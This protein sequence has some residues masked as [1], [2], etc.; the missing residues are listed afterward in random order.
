VPIGV[1]TLW[2]ITKKPAVDHQKTGGRS[3][4]TGALNVFCDTPNRFDTGSAGRA[5]V[6][7]SF[8]GVAINATAQGQ[9]VATLRSGLP[10]NREIGQAVGVLLTRAAEARAFP[11]LRC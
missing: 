1:D 4:K 9:D 7:A 2:S 6:L 10:S 5:I 11:P 3:P 8:A